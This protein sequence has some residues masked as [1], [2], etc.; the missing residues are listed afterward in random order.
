[1]IRIFVGCLAVGL[2]CAAWGAEEPCYGFSYDDHVSGEHLSVEWQ[3]EIIDEDEAVV[4]LDRM[5]EAYEVYTTD[6]GWAHP[7][8]D[9]SVVV[10]QAAIEGAAYGV[11]QTR[12]CDDGTYLARL[13]VFGEAF[14]AGA[15][16]TTGPHELGHAFEYGYM[17]SYLDGLAAWAWWMEG[18][19]TWFERYV[20][21]SGA[22][23]TQGSWIASMRNYTENPHL[24]LHH[25]FIDINDPQMGPHMYGTAILAMYL[26]EYYGADLV[27]QTWEIGGNHSGEGA[28]WFPDVIEEAGVDFDALWQGYI[29]AVGTLD[30]EDG[31][32]INERPRPTTVTSLPASGEPKEKKRPQGLG[33]SYVKVRSG[34]GAPGRTLKLAFD[35]DPEAKW[36]VVTFLTKED[37]AGSRVKQLTPL[38]VDEAGHAEVELAFDGDRHVWMGVSPQTPGRDGFAY[39][40]AAE[41]IGGEEEA[42]G[43]CAC[44]ASTTGRTPMGLWITLLLGLW[45]RRERSAGPVRV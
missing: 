11:A 16:M 31:E 7:P 23:S 13:Q 37:K 18:T 38:V 21:G 22:Y 24:A 40:W 29:A 2:T 14:R 41:G 33:L 39:S 1:M 8:G 30:F 26:D 3:P 6:L 44:A 36:H 34:L 5:E 19:A 28:L 25:D 27:R 15:E 20:D 45:W 10:E 43:G 17:G 42:P 35:G 9:M 4:F 32:L 12:E